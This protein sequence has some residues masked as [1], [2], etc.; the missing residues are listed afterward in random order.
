MKNRALK[1]TLILIFI[2][3]V[4]TAI[5]AFLVWSPKSIEKRNAPFVAL[6]VFVKVKLEQTPP[7]F[8]KAVD[9]DATVNFEM[10]KQKLFIRRP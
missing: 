3:V 10:R 8:E 6:G 5:M 2:G 4:I 1:Y 7:L 9:G